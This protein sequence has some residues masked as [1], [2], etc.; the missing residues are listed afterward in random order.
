MDDTSESGGQNKSGELYEV[1]KFCTE[2]GNVAPYLATLWRRDLE[3]R[4]LCN[5]LTS[6][7]DTKDIIKKGSMISMAPTAAMEAMLCLPPLHIVLETEA[8]MA[9]YRLEISGHGAEITAISAC[10]QEMTYTNKRIQIISDSQAALKALGVVEIHSQPELAKAKNEARMSKSKFKAMTIVFFDI[11]GIVYV[12]WVSEGKT[13]NKYYYIEVLAALRERMRRRR[14]DLWKTKSWKMHQDNAPVHSA[15][16]VK[17]FL[18]NTA[19]PAATTP[20]DFCLFPRVKSGLKGT[21]FECVE[22]VKAKATEVLNQLTEADFQHRFQQWKNRM[23]RCR[24]RQGDTLKA[25]K[26]LL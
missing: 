24:D 14:P 17:A 11:R 23:E 8:L 2:T 22:A 20:C 25:K 26:L 3:G 15:L 12:H 1:C 9:A 7:K 13:V 18:Q 21:R 6:V 16:S 5:I 10:A 19:L 4:S